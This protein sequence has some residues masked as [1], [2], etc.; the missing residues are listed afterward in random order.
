[1]TDGLV[2]VVLLTKDSERILSRCVESIYKNVPVAQLI[3]VDGYSKD[4]TLEIMRGFNEK[5]HNVKIIMDKGTRAT[6]RQKGIE[7]VTAEWF[8]FVDSDVVL[9]KDWYK[10]A[11]R[12]LQPDVGAV[13]GIEVW[14]T[15]SNPKTMRLFL[16]TTRRIFEVRGGTHDTLIRTSLVKDIKI[17]GSL[18]VFEDAYIKDW[19]SD[20]GYRVIACYSPFCIHYRPQTVWTL[21]G[22]LGL[23]SESLRIGSPRLVQKLFFAYGF[24]T[25]YSVYQLLSHK[26]P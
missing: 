15:I 1:M 22:S 23:I 5:Y 20:K 18:H 17:P 14:S 26:M 3:V 25:V 10:K 2:D 9:C 16:T 12:Y 19:I 7:N 13:W 11:Q 21:Q 24:Y 4:K 6:A 8:M